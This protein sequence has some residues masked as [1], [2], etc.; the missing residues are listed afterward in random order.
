M[1]FKCG[2]QRHRRSFWTAPFRR[3]RP[4]VLPTSELW[5]QRDFGLFCRTGSWLCG[6]CYDV[7]STNQN[8]VPGQN[9]AICNKARNF[10]DNAVRASP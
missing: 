10:S 6:L 5:L 8:A 9:V 3:C 1:S 2:R 4:F 7:N